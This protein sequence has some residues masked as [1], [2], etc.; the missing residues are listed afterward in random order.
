MLGGFGTARRAGSDEGCACL[1]HPSTPNEPWQQN[2][3]NLQ[4]TAS[5]Q[6]MTSEKIFF[7]STAVFDKHMLYMKSTIS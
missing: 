2:N 7:L 5:E 6:M 4:N 3:M 1:Q